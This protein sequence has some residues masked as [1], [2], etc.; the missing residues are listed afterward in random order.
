MLR[1]LTHS[2]GAEHAECADQNFS[3]H[4]RATVEWRGA[5]IPITDGHWHLVHTQRNTHA[6]GSLLAVNE[7][8]NVDE[9]N[10]RP[11]FAGPTPL[12]P[13]APHNPATAVVVS[14]LGVLVGIGSI[15]HGVLEA[16][17]GNR[18]TPGLIINALG[19]G[20][21]W[22]VWTQGGE[23]AFTVLPNFLL[24]GILATLI[25]L[26]LI[27]WSLRFI[28][29]PHGP[30]VFL[31]LSVTS[32]LV[33]GGVAQILLFTLNWAAA[34][35]IQASLGFWRRLVPGPMRPVLGRFWRWTLVAAT[36]L[37][38]AGLEIAVIGYVPGVS[39]QIKIL[40]VCWTLLLIALALIFFSFLSGFAHDLDAASEASPL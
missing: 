7:M 38:L 31:L 35:R 23:P 32:F 15:N 25:G 27:V 28:H 22:T 6:T 39:G 24:T 37:F 9:Q 30:S 8:S 18:P 11:V 21:H 5:V 12:P 29:K 10:A 17:Q 13:R 36:V 3:V 34:T 14:T 1:Q 16:V 4:T 2:S 26:L 20:Y 40:H 19:P 33:G